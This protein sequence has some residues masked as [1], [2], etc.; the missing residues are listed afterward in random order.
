MARPDRGLPGDPVKHWTRTIELLLAGAFLTLSTACSRTRQVDAKSLDPANVKVE[1][2][3]DSNT[4]QIDRPERFP[5][6]KVESR[7]GVDELKV[8][9]VVAPD[10]NRTVPV[11]A[12]SM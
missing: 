3:A 4:I 11:N 7:T 12:L 2:I 1:E 8:N 5:L 10:V 9:G 6:V